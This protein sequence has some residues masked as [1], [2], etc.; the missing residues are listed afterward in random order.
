MR[1]GKPATLTSALLARKGEAEPARLTDGTVPKDVIALQEE[2]VARVAADISRE[3]S[4]GAAL[5][6]VAAAIAP[7]K[8][9]EA[10]APDSSAG[11][12]PAII[13]AEETAEAAGETAEAEDGGDAL[14]SAPI[15]L[16]PGSADEP[17]YDPAEGAAAA[18]ESQITLADWTARAQS[19]DTPFAYERMTDA[20]EPERSAFFLPLVLAVAVVAVIATLAIWQLSDHGQ[21]YPEG[22]DVR[23]VQTAAMPAAAPAEPAAPAPVEPPAPTVAE[24][25]TPAPAQAV[26]PAPAPV[27]GG[28]AVQLISTVSQETAERAWTGIAAKVAATG[29]KAPH[30]IDKADLGAKGVRYR[31]KLTGFPSYAAGQ[32]ACE[33]LKARKIGC[34]V[35]RN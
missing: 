11:P 21:L 12:E 33:T 26:E 17:D 9:A 4:G 28:Y 18:Q 14:G 5:P 22:T 16:P 23:A 34:L 24:S 35:I 19:G 10:T 25:P 8:P 13:A 2:L 20:G 1:K 6:P 15:E 31:V 29:L 7:E 32:K 30:A 27:A 3:A